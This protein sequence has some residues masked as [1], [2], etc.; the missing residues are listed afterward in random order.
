MKHQRQFDAGDAASK[1]AVQISK[2]ISDLDRLARILDCEIAAE[3]QHAYVFD[4]SDAAYPYSQGRWQRGATIL[5]TPSLRSSCDLQALPWRQSPSWH[6][7]KPPSL[8]PAGLSSW[9]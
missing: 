6:K 5:W 4:R 1:E 2:M 8:G 3:E 7:K 9:G